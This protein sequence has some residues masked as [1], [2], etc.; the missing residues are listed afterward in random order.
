MDPA[1]LKLTAELAAIRLREGELE[2]LGVE[3]ERML[4]YFDVMDS[5][6]TSSFEPTTHASGQCVSL[7]RDETGE[8]ASGPDEAGRAVSSIDSMLDQAGD[9]ESRLIVIP[10]VL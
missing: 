7:R 5:I 8:A 1:E 4:E 10:N 3:V 6:D 9:L 2:R